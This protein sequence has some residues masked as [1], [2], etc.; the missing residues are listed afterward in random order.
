MT[1][2]KAWLQ[3]HVK[4]SLKCMH[5]G[6]PLQNIQFIVKLIYKGR[7]DKFVPESFRIS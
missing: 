2:L 6:V 7:D 1:V 4:G 5:C 3:I